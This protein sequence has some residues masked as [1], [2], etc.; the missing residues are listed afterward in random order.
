MTRGDRHSS[1]SGGGDAFDIAWAVD[2]SG[3]PA[4]LDGF[5]FIRIATAV[6]VNM[7]GLGEASSE[8]DAVAD[9]SPGPTG[10][11]VKAYADGTGARLDNAVVTAGFAGELYVQAARFS[12]I[13]IKSS[14]TVA[15]GDRVTA[16][17]EIHTAGGERVI[18]TLD[19]GG[20]GHDAFLRLVDHEGI[21]PAPVGMPMSMWVVP[22][23]TRTRRCHRRQGPEQPRPA[24]DH[25]RRGEV[26]A[27]RLLLHFR[28]FAAVRSGAEGSGRADL[29]EPKARC[30]DRRLHLRD[31]RAERSQGRASAISSGHCRD[32]IDSRDF[33]HELR[34]G[35]P[36]SDMCFG[37]SVP[38]RELLPEGDR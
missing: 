18:C 21:V 2:S 22:R 30:R 27:Q 4:N 16:I 26:E 31:G 5:D 35:C 20:T 17:G 8:I 24:R 29:A 7:G 14:T 37:T 1:S 10:E 12:G 34:A 36:E 9:A 25:L 28:R 32:S 3:N 23:S 15:P 6:D 33:D 38:Q 19:R 11:F 13:K